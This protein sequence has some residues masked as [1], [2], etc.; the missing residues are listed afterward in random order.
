MRI[1]AFITD[2]PTV[3]D[4]LAHLGQPTAPPTVA[5]AVAAT[6]GIAAAAARDRSPGP[7]GTGLRVR[8]ARRLG[9]DERPS[10]VL[11]RRRA[12]SRLP[13]V[14]PAGAHVGGASYA[15]RW[16][17]TPRRRPS[18]DTRPASPCDAYEDGRRW[19]AIR[20]A[21]PLSVVRRRRGRPLR[22]DCGHCD[23]Y[24]VM[25]VARSTAPRCHPGR[26]AHCQTRRVRC[27]CANAQTAHFPT[28]KKG[29]YWVL[30]TTLE[31]SLTNSCTDCTAS[32]CW[33]RASLS[34]SF[35]AGRKPKRSPCRTSGNPSSMSI[36]P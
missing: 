29:H 1:I 9:V 6:S 22:R 26:P 19:C 7:A 13:V 16:D 21:F 8:S 27:V 35:D 31:V 4:I 5:P 12:A 24:E 30:G 20:A 17:S 10:V 18:S 15:R 28:G 25:C 33:H 34:S 32:S 11:A 2:G 3:R 36:Y 23:K 14:M